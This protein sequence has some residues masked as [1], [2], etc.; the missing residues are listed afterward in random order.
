MS[1]RLGDTRFAAVEAFMLSC[2]SDSAH[3]AEH[4]YRV[5][6][7]ALTIARSEAGA[8]MNVLVTACLLHD[9][10][11]ARQFANPE[12]DHA[13]VGAEMAREWLRSSGAEPEFAEAVAECV[14]A[15]RYRSGNPPQS[16]EARILFDA[17]KL[18]ICGAIG[19]ARTLLYEGHEALPLYTF[20]A[21]GSV[22][23]GTSDETESFFHEYKFKLEGLYGRFLTAKGAELAES[24]RSTA[25]NFYDNL[26]AEV[27]GCYT[28]DLREGL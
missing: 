13:A 25:A 16:V 24:R 20:G 6:N 11:R 19:V 2:M 1:A 23:D 3:D 10:G 14:A 26:L 21:D 22:S 5:L 12:L 9:V 15:H 7:N 18:D 27:R 17:D 8:D 4:V 28:F